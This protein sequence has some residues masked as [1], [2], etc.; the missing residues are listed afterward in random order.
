MDRYTVEKVAHGEG[1]FGHILKGRDNVLE[2]DVAVKVLT[3]LAKID[4]TNADRLRREAR[5]LASL[6]HPSI[7]SIYD[8]IFDD[9][10]FL[11]LFQFIHGPTLAK[12]TKDEGPVA[13]TLAKQWFLQ[14]SSALDHAHSIGIVHRDI[15]PANIIVTPNNETAYLVDFGI[16]ISKDDSRK[17]TAAGYAMG[18]AGYL[19]PELLSGDPADHR[20]DIYALGITLYEVLAGKRF[21]V[22]G[23][24]DLS[25]ANEAIS[26]QI[27]D[28]IRDCILP[29][30][31]R[32]W[33]APGSET[34]INV[35]S[36]SLGCC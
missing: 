22:A 18:T 28:L 16:A 23:Y 31:K 21:P 34:V 17:L 25:L 36:A 12:V 8:V 11:V 14:I 30:D 9:T 7:P 6:S 29:A 20:A 1:G 27:D 3:P 4:P 19:A 15:K 13:I 35:V 26:P 10:N 32:V 33:P 5:F 24:E 2:R